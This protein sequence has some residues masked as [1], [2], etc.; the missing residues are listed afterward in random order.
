MSIEDQSRWFELS[1]GTLSVKVTVYEAL[2]YSQGYEVI[3]G[4]STLRTMNGT[5]IKQT[6]WQKIKT[7]LSGSGGLPL[8]MSDL[9]YSLP[10]TIKCG[11]PR[12]I[13]RPTNSFSLVVPHRTDQ[14]YA[15]I[16]LKLVEGFWVPLASSGT[17]TSFM[18]LYY[19]LLTCFFKPPQENF[20]WDGSSPSSWSLSGDEI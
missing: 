20:S 3:G 18:L 9:N 16:T 17:G 8:G 5:A 1:D 15:P 12:A 13:V 2:N 10:I 7:S 11:T 4:D 19:P 14:G 6:N